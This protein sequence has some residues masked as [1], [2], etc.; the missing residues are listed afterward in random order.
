MENYHPLI[1]ALDL[2]EG[3]IRSIVQGYLNPFERLAVECA[4]AEEE[5]REAATAQLAEAGIFKEVSDALT[6]AFTEEETSLIVAFYEGPGGKAMLE[7][8]PGVFSRIH[9]FQRGKGTAILKVLDEKFDTD[10]ELARLSEEKIENMAPGLAESLKN[11][12][13][14]AVK[15]LVPEEEKTLH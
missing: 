14:N 13:Q 10:A 3:L 4:I 2:K 1:D 12:I 6:E 7:K 15:Q 5:I 11:V 9:D 8:M